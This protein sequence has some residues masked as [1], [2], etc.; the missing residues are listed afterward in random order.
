VRALDRQEPAGML[1]RGEV[2]G[3]S[4]S[5]REL[6]R[7]RRGLIGEKKSSGRGKMRQ[8]RDLRKTRVAREA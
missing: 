1:G 2:A 3:S 5:S 4:G 6:A 8:A 7:S